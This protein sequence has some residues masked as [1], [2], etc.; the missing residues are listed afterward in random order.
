MP[1]S[2][3]GQPPYTQ[4][5]GQTLKTCRLLTFREIGTIPL[6]QPKKKLDPRGTPVR[7]MYGND[8]NK[9]TVQEINTKRYRAV[10]SA[11]FRPYSSYYDPCH[12]PTNPFKPQT[13]QHK[14]H[15]T[16]PAP[17]THNEA[18]A[19]PNAAQRAHARDDELK[20]LD[21]NKTIKWLPDNQL[22]PCE[23]LIPL[24]MT[25]RYKRAPDGK[26]TQRKGRCSA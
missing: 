25:Y 2:A 11:D 20:K 1:H 10:R 13:K 6:L 4:W 18:R 9:I 16:P 19:Y 23:R 8:P 12:S 17:T 3:T 22:P 24:K 15:I 26:V 21:Q 7:Y 5:H 14:I